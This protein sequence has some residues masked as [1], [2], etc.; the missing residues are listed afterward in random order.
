[1]KKILIATLILAAGIG[2]S[3]AQK[4]ANCKSA[5]PDN[6]E[7]TKAVSP[8][9]PKCCTANPFEGLNLTQE[10]QTKIDALKAECKTRC[11]K[12]KADK[13]ERRA[14]RASQQRTNRADMLAKL[15]ANPY[16]EQYV[17]FLETTSSTSA[18]TCP[19]RATAPPISTAST[20]ANTDNL[21]IYRNNTHTT[22]PQNSNV[23]GSFYCQSGQKHV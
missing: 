19:V 23:C 20:A 21:Q 12:A 4:P 17:K 13:K 3:F 14:E 8:R 9:E 16:P 11:D 1:M 10:Q 6:K 2:S 22:E 7:C 5:C 18:T 15:K